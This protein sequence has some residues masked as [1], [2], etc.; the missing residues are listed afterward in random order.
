LLFAIGLAEARGN[1]VFPPRHV[2]SYKTFFGFVA[3]LRL[4]V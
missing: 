1:F 4:A 3:T 2:D